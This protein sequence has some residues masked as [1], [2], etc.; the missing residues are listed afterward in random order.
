MY[1]YELCRRYKRALGG[2]DLEAVLALFTD[3][4]EVRAPITGALPAR[5]FHQ[6]LF[7]RGRG[8]IARLVNVFDSLGDP[9]T[10]A[11]QFSYTWILR[12]GEVLEIDGITVFDIDLVLQKIARM[13]VIYD[14]TELRS[15]LHEDD[16]ESLMLA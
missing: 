14:P 3:D 15:R 5:V 7:A 12:N 6:R 13:T 9:T 10:V 8:A 4:A 16:I 11:L 1:G 2:Q